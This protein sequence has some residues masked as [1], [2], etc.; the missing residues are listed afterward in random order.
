M[1]SLSHCSVWQIAV[2]GNVLTLRSPFDLPVMPSLTWQRAN[3]ICSEF[4]LPISME[5]VSHQSRLDLSRLRNSKVC[6][7]PFLYSVTQINIFST[8][9]G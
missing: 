8:T 5:T 9:V 1:L 2:R 7:C 3:N 6:L 4:C